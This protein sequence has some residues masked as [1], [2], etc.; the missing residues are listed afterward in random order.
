MASSNS[1]SLILDAPHSD[2]ADL[3]LPWPNSDDTVAFFDYSGR[4]M[5]AELLFMELSFTPLCTPL[6]FQT[7]PLVAEWAAI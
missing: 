6:I 5:L 2:M 7:H 1:R 3:Y 4:M